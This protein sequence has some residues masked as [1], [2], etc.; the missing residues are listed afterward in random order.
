MEL[1]SSTDGSQPPSQT[2]N[3]S[4]VLITNEKSSLQPIKSRGRINVITEKLVAT[5]DKCQISDRNTVRIISAVAE[6]I[7]NV[8][9]STLII[10][11]KSIN[12]YRQ[13]IRKELSHKIKNLFHPSQMNAAVLHWDGK[14]MSNIHNTGKE[15]RLAIVLSSG[16]VEK[17]LSI[18]A[19]A[20][21]IAEVNTFK[22]N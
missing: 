19:Q 1:A 16:K 12:F 11:K 5:L 4:D 17:I 8:D 14:I 22:T 6:A 20:E 3:F 15:D 21:M 9:V 2:S 13:K 10:N 7:G 18:P